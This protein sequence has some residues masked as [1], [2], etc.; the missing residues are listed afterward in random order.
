MYNV[1]ID[2]RE[3]TPF[4]FP[5]GN[6]CTGSVIKKLDTG[7]YTLEGLEDKLCIE[8]KKVVSEIAQNITQERF[9]EELIRMTNFKYRYI[10]FEF[11][12]SSVLNFPYGCGLPKSVIRKVRCRGKF[13]EH[14]LIGLNMKYGIYTH[15]AGSTKNA[16]KFCISIMDMVWKIENGK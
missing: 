1:L 7:D 13:L 5:E 4:L 10:I 8:R 3:K 6:L 16:N 15:Y 12:W 11:D 2:T 14:A 9:K